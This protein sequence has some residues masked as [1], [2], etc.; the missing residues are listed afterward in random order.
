MNNTNCAARIVAWAG[1]ALGLWSLQ[2]PPALAQGKVAPG[3]LL[4]EV[5]VR[6]LAPVTY[7]YVTTETTFDKLGETIGETM[8]KFIKAAEAGKIKPGGPFVLRYPEGSAHKAPLKPFKV[9]I[10][11]MVIADSAGDEEVKVKRSE[12]FKAATL[13]YTGPVSQ[14]GQSYQKLFPAIERMGLEPTGEEREFTLYWED[15]ESANNVVMIQVGVKEKARAAGA[16]PA[17]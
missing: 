3:P 17:K 15:L 1:I 12:P 11:M 16:A 10:G 8:P 6:D 5:R 4:G 9:E 7:A 14:I 13:L 2:P